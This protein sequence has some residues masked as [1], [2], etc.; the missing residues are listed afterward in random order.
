M[1][2][3]QGEKTRNAIEIKAIL[4]FANDAQAHPPRHSSILTGKQEFSAEMPNLDRLVSLFIQDNLQET[5]IR[6]THFCSLAGK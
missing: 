3:E 5:G 1:K 2:R 4:D 6:E